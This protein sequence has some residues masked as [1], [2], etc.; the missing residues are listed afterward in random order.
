MCYNTI[1]EKEITYYHSGCLD[2]SQLVNTA[3]YAAE[4]KRR[5]KLAR[6]NQ[7]AQ[8]VRRPNIQATK[9]AL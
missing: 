4:V 5:E 9:A 2:N 1:M 3:I 7:Q 8:A 6:Y